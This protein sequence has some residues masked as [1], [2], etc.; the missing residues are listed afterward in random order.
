MKNQYILYICCPC[1]T[2]WILRLNPRSFIN[3][4]HYKKKNSTF[5]LID[6]NYKAENGLLTKASLLKT[7]SQCDSQNWPHKTRYT[8]F[9]GVKI[10]V[11]FHTCSFPK[12]HF[13][14]SSV[15]MKYSVEHCGWKAITQ[16]M[17]IYL[18]IYWN[19]GWKKLV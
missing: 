6:Q 13:L 10:S 2:I 19:K 8:I 11:S 3:K 4:E 12:P 1:W 5:V 17:F 16:Y 14:L 18:T 7:L 15:L 9:H